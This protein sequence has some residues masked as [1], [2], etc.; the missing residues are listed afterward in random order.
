MGMNNTRILYLFSFDGSVSWRGMTLAI[1]RAAIAIELHRCAQAYMVWNTFGH[2]TTRNL[3]HLSE[4]FVAHAL[5]TDSSV[6]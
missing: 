6:Q 5:K 1:E 4:R 2:V 3:K